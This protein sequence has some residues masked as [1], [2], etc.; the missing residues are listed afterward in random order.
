MGPVPGPGGSKYI[1]L[2][3]GTQID[4]NKAKID[5]LQSN[6]AD[7][8]N[9]RLNGLRV[10]GNV[11]R[12]NHLVIVGIAAKELRVDA[13]DDFNDLVCHFHILVEHVHNGL[14]HNGVQRQQ[15]QHGNKAPQAAAAHGN[16]LFPI[17]VLH[18]LILAGGIIG[19]TALNFLQLGRQPGHFHHALFGFRGNGQ[20]H[21]LHNN[22][23]QNQREAVVIGQPIQSLHQ[24]A[25]GHLDDVCNVKC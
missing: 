16:P 17:Q 6:I 4:A 5:A 21:Q 1:K 10:L 23:K 20:E 25:E 9:G 22:G 8:G 11:L 15:Q 3:H 2:G 12:G 19:I 18:G 24:V 13:L 7:G 14:T